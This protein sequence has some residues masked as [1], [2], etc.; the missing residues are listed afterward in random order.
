MAAAAASVL[1]GVGSAT[2]DNCRPIDDVPFQASVDFEQRIQPLFDRY[3]TVC[4]RS[5]STFLDLSAGAAGSQLVGRP[6]ALDPTLVRVVPGDP[7][8]SLLVRKLRCAPPFGTQM[9]PTFPLDLFA[10]ATVD[11]WIRGGAVFPGDGRIFPN[12]FESRPATDP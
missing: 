6:S 1:L 2:A 5:G 11:D 3:C 4:H 9:P 12:N 10:L 8:A 7:T